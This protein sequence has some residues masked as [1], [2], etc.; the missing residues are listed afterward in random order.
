MGALVKPAVTAIMTGVCLVFQHLPLALAAQAEDNTEQTSEALSPNFPLEILIRPRPAPKADGYYENGKLETIY[1]QELRLSGYHLSGVHRRLIDGK[2][3]YDVW[4]SQSN[5][6]TH[7]LMKE[8]GLLSLP[9]FEE[10]L[11]HELVYG[12]DIGARMGGEYKGL[13]LLEI[14]YLF[15]FDAAPPRKGFGSSGIIGGQAFN[16]DYSHD[17]MTF[18]VIDFRSVPRN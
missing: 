10:R 18:G 4:Q 17:Q 6:L 9:S 2:V 1:G 5:L 3:V 12:S 7:N 8:A 14:G 11:A 13:T 15:N 16:T